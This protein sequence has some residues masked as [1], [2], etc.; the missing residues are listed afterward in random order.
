MGT[1]TRVEFE[2]ESLPQAQLFQS[3]NKGPKP[4]VPNPWLETNRPA[5]HPIFSLSFFL[6]FLDW[7]AICLVFG[8][9]C[10]LS[11]TIY[12]LSV[13]TMCWDPREHSKQELKATSWLKLTFIFKLHLVFYK[14]IIVTKTSQLIK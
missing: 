2:L 10:L 13:S 3:H 8:N 9:G 6:P 5:S 7:K 11:P 12:G 1:H 14:N 4:P